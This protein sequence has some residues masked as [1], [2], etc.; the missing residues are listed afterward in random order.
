VI[1]VELVNR[2][3][4]GVADDEVREF[5]LDILGREN[6]EGGE[7]GLWFVPPDEIRAL[8]AEHLGIDEITD[9]LSFP[10]DGTAPLAEGQPRALGDIF[11]CPQVVEDAWRAPLAHGLLH[12]L[13]YEHSARMVRR[14]QEL[15]T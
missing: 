8:K 3:G 15:L 7:L 12:L 4:I 9:V 14:E 13:G 5:A 1:R 6:V 2:S 11:I 10:M